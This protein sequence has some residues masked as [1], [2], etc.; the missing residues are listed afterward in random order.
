MAVVAVP[1][2]DKV[3]IRRARQ[4]RSPLPLLLLVGALLDLFRTH[5]CESLDEGG[6][7]GAHHMPGHQLQRID[8]AE[9]PLCRS[10]A[11]VSGVCGREQTQVPLLYQALHI[12]ESPLREGVAFWRPFLTTSCGLRQDD[13]GKASPPTATVRPHTR[14]ERFSSGALGVHSAVRVHH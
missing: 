7:A 5:C 4:S 14:N 3:R 11:A 1:M 2:R 8:A 6:L 13:G 9:R 10:T 12:R